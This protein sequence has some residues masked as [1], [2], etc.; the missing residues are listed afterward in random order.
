MSTNYPHPDRAVSTVMSWPISTIDH[1]ATLEEA[2]EALAAD[3]IGAVLVLGDEDDLVGI[4]SERDVVQHVAAGA[5]LAH[6]DVGE[7]MSTDLVTAQVDDTLLA[8]AQIMSEAGVRHIPV[9]SGSL[10]AGMLSMRDLFDVLLA[11]S[12]QDEVVEVPNDTR[13]VVRQD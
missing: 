4:L 12:G 8:A 11:A 3:E 2:A 9:L 13:V 7:V 1:G 6:L 5:T 10:I